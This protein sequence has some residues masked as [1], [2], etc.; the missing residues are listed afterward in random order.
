MPTQ[1]GVQLI[2]EAA[3]GRELTYTPEAGLCR[4][5]GGS[6]TEGSLP[7]AKTKSNNWTSEAD[8][9]EKT[10]DFTCAACNWARQRASK[11]V[12]WAIPKDSGL[13]NHAVVVSKKVGICHP[14][15][16][17]FLD[18]LCDASLYPAIFGINRNTN[19]SHKHNILMIGGSLS[20]SSENVN[21]WFN[22]IRFA[23]DFSGLDGVVT[24][25][26]EHFRAE[27]LTLTEAI[28]R[29]IDPLFTP[30]QSKNEAYSRFTNAFC[31]LAMLHKEA[32]TGLSATE[33]LRDYLACTLMAGIQ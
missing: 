11:N 24:V 10:S 3:T 22:R 18:M 27:V 20:E 29:D 15:N 23:P 13:N 5:C 17:E 16:R 12:L 32:G 33:T 9:Q 31:T 8:C 1:T 30:K 2:Y 14:D 21:I 28:K 19:I 4:I 6:L 26:A 25:N 7:Y